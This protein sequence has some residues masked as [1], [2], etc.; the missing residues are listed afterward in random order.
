M[1][2]DRRAM[3]AYTLTKRRGELVFMAF[4]SG[5]P[6]NRH[7][8]FRVGRQ[9]FLGSRSS[10]IAVFV[11]ITVIAIERLQ[12]ISENEATDVLSLSDPFLDGGAEVN[13]RV[14]PGLAVLRGGLGKARVGP[15]QAGKGD[16]ARGRKRDVVVMEEV[17]QDR[18]GGAAQHAVG[19]RV[20]R[21]RRRVQQRRPCRIGRSRVV[22]V[23]VAGADRGHR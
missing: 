16:T 1:G 8:F 3:R 6:S 15:R 2:I 22:A 7:K 20:V 5:G 4:S 23:R 10:L 13:P 11:A 18:R 12:D 17:A 19:R 14:D 21:Y 9:A